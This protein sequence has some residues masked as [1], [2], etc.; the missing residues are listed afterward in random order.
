MRVS[1]F[2]DD[3]GYHPAV[4][5]TKVFFEGTEISRVFTADEER[6]MVVVA[7]VDEQGRVMLTPDRE[8]VATETRYGSV[9]LELSA[10]MNRMLT[11]R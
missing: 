3:P 2:S 5:G 4:F 1:V 8:E 11:G 7:K 6:R 10:A 9:R